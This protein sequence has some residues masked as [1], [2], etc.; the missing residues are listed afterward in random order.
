MMATFQSPTTWYPFCAA[1][2]FINTAYLDDHRSYWFPILSYLRAVE[3]AGGRAVLPEELKEKALTLRLTND[4]LSYNEVRICIE[5]FRSLVPNLGSRLIST[6]W[7]SSLDGDQFTIGAHGHEHER[8][9]LMSEEW[10]RNDLRENIRMLSRFRSYKPIFAVPF[11]RPFD[12]TE[13]TIQIARDEGLDIVLADGGINLVA[14][15]FY[16]RIPSD[17]RTLDRL[18]DDAMAR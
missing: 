6:E 18:L 7:L 1:T 2:F 9:S 15:N 16:Q 11:G 3:N 8:F 5:E 14:V 4:P 12:W 13:K 17:N 10:Q